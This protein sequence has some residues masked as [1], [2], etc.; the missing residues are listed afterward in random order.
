MKRPLVLACL[1][2]LATALP[3]QAG[4][5]ISSGNNPQPDEENVLFNEVGL[6][7]LGNPV[8]GLTSQ[9]NLIVTF[10]GNETLVTS[11]GAEARVEAL[12][13][14]L[15]TYELALP[16]ATFLDYIFNLNVAGIP[17]T[18]PQTGTATIRVNASA[19]SSLTG[20]FTIGSGENFFT[21]IATGNDRLDSVQVASTLALADVRQNRISGAA[22][23]TT[24]EPVSLLLV[25]TGLAF[26]VV[27]RRR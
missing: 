5:I 18:V 20:N 4:L 15:T 14:S 3:S 19:G 6:I 10:S 17:G 12:D 24:P 1:L 23:T 7:S 26:G 16:G 11:S 21:V 8:T 25:G 9:S 27:R 2:L 22:T 13:G